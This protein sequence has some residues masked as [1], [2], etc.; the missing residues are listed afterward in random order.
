[1]V[2]H[3]QP[4]LKPASHG[5]G[6]VAVRALKSE[7]ERLGVRD[8]TRRRR[9]GTAGRGEVTACPREVRSSHRTL[10]SEPTTRPQHVK[11][12][13]VKVQPVAWPVYA[14]GQTRRSSAWRASLALVELGLGVGSALLWPPQ[15]GRCVSRGDGSISGGRY[16]GDARRGAAASGA[17]GCCERRP[18]LCSH[19]YIAAGTSGCCC[20][21]CLAWSKLI[22]CGCQPV[23]G[24]MVHG[25]WYV[26][27]M[28]RMGRGHGTYGTVRHARGWCAHGAVGTSPGQ[29]ALRLRYVQHAGGARSPVR[30][31]TRT[32]RRPRDDCT[33]TCEHSASPPRGGRRQRGSGQHKYPRA[34]AP[35]S[36]VTAM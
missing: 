14:A 2:E 16:T 15:E 12:Q 8:E 28:V 21:H 24:N 13:H 9:I 3:T 5:L 1:M 11:V 34:A 32:V 36:S 29:V 33:C 6:R 25:T 23:H 27:Y 20:S 18:H 19:L 22:T 35:R 7:A 10:S 26:W 30:T 4:R 31:R 17:S